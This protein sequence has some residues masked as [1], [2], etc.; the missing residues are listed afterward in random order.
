[1]SKMPITVYMCA[2][3]S[4]QAEL[5]LNLEKLYRHFNYTQVHLELKH[6][7]LT[8]SAKQTVLIHNSKINTK[9]PVINK[10]TDISNLNISN[11]KKLL[12]DK[13][14]EKF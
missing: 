2:Q 8:K 4:R 6:H 3:P 10:K 11:L 9:M 13:T 1:M 5:R 14:K 12:R 7:S